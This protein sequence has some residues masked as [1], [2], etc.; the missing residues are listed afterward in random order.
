MLFPK[1]F[2][3]EHVKN[4]KAVSIMTGK[5]ITVSFD[6]PVALQI[7]GEVVPEVTT[8]TVTASSL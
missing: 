8:Y 7:D 1:I 2:K 4:E 3:G 6:R 5:S